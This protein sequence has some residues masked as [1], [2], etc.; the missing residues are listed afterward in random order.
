MNSTEVSSL[1]AHNT[2]DDPAP[3]E[4][5]ASRLV[6]V[7][8]PSGGRHER[9]SKRKTGNEGKIRLLEEGGE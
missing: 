7:I 8:G 3:F 1:A 5:A 4:A 2:C 9:K 6:C